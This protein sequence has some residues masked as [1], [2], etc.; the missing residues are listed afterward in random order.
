MLH[1]DV[2]MP[3]SEVVARLPLGVG[4]L[5]LRELAPAAPKLRVARRVRPCVRLRS[6]AEL[7]GQHFGLGE[8]ALLNGTRHLVENRHRDAVF[9]PGGFPQFTCQ[10]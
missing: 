2:A 8:S 6:L 10:S 1:E 7:G 9:I 3:H 5:S 4:Q